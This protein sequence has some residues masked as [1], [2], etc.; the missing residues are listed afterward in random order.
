MMMAKMLEMKM[1]MKMRMVLLSVVLA[2]LTIS[3]RAATSAGGDVGILYE[4][5]HTEAAQAMKKVQSLGGKQLTT[6]LVIR[7]NGTFTLDDVYGPYNISADIYN[8]Q[9][10]LGFY[11]LYRKRPSDPNPPVSDCDNI[12]KTAQAHALL[13]SAAGIDYVAIDITNWPTYNT[14]TDIAVV[15]PTEVLFE[16]WSALRAQNVSTP[17]IALW[18]CSPTNSTTWRYLLQNIYNNPNYTD[19]IYKQNDKMTFFLPYRPGSCYSPSEE[20]AIQSNFGGNNVST[21]KMWAL[22]GEDT[23]TQNVWGFFSPCV[24]SRTGQYT[25]SMV[26]ETACNQY[27][28]TDQQGNVQEV[29]ASGSYMLSQSALPFAAPG[30]MRGLT[31]QR[32]FAKVLEQKAPHLFISSFNE[33]IGGRQAPASSAKVAF[34]MGLPND[35]QRMSVWVDTYGSEFSRD[36]EPTVEGGARP[37]QVMRSC[38]TLYKAGLTCANSPASACCST[39]DKEIWANI[40]SLSLGQDNLLTP[41]EAERDA[42]VNQGWQEVCSPIV[43]PSVFCVDTSNPDGRNGPFLLYNQSSAIT[44]P[45]YRCYDPSR[46][47]HS[48]S[49][50]SSCPGLGHMEMILGYAARGPGGETLRALRRCRS[51]TTTAYTHALDLECDTNDSPILGYVR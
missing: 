9:P 10:Q 24:S 27:P 18:V 22:F 50:D 1:K 8:V 34:N 7:S 48:V 11:C 23:Y 35:P 49:D 6:E 26:G 13:L 3:S 32:L 2:V 39:E 28:S 29:S 25:T 31:L 44:K 21:I 38:V 42:L 43:G 40:W 16:E 14:E 17:Q 51:T 4:V 33:H 30:H 47:L 46:G 20:I 37:Y 36:L 15:R 19:L 41:N 5:W 12:T 45:I